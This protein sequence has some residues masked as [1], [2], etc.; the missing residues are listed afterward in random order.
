MS[1]SRI[2]GLVL[3]AFTLSACA[4]SIPPVPMDRF[5][6]GDL[7]TIEQFFAHELAE[8]DERSRALFLTGLGQTE[9]LGGKLEPARQHIS[10]AAR[11][12]GTWATSGGE[13]TGAVLGQEGSKTWRGDPHE[14]AMNAFYL[15]LL[16]WWRGEPDNARAA[17][18]AGILAD[19][20]SDEG[21]AQ[22]DFALL[23]WLAGRA[24]LLMGLRG[25][26]EQFFQEAR[27][28]RAFAV[29]NGA[30][31]SSAPAILDDP[32]AG[33]LIV[34]A[35]FDLGPAKVQGGEHGEY[36][37]VAPREVWHDRAEVFVDGASV[38]EPMLL[39]DLDYQART[40][41]GREMA[42]I[43]EGKAVFKDVTETAGTVLLYAGMLDRDRGARDK[44]LAGGALLLASLFSRP[45][46]DVRHWEILPQ[47]VA[48]LAVAVEPGRHEVRIV[49]S[50][51]AAGRLERVQFV[52]VA[53]R[54]DALVLFR[55]IPG[56]NPTP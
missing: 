16:H 49:F 30:R 34:L 2:L 45:E 9:L 56:P 24:S 17:F 28:A 39:V 55:S 35:E 12:M 22:V 40:R 7:D 25:D 8:G 15:G 20:E 13:T 5:L 51:G 54:T 23:F 4:A 6:G 53:E 37:V 26:A 48:A 47:R 32:G 29:R 11:I 33:N 21:E 42:G 27:N 43:R 50:G 52:D 46:A 41:G 31:G 19:A 1:P 18:K 36:A 10:E 44:L 38:G 3:L 14:K